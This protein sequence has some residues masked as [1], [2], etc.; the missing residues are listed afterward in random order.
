MVLSVN[1]TGVVGGGG[2]D[3]E[4]RRGGGRNH[5]ARCYTC[6]LMPAWHTVHSE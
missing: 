6:F 5:G 2:G 3:G 1:Q 4:D